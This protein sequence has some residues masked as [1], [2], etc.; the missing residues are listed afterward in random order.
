VPPSCMPSALRHH[1]GALCLM[2]NTKGLLLPK[3]V[4]LGVWLSV[5]QLKSV[6]TAMNIPHPNGTG[7]K[8]RRLK[9]DYARSLVNSLHNDATNDDKKRMISAIMSGRKISDSDLC[10]AELLQHLSGLDPDNGFSFKDLKAVAF[11]KLAEVG[12]ARVQATTEKAGPTPGLKLNFTPELLKQFEPPT[13]HPCWLQRYAAYKQYKGY[14]Q[15]W[16]L[17]CSESLS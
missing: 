2:S 16:A 14:Y 10:P 13:T 11:H 7:K 12:T 5:A 1:A 8:N 17:T 3:A 15:R 9:I 6:H 4:L